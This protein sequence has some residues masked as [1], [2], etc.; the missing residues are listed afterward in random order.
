MSC[1]DCG[2]TWTGP[3]YDNDINETC[4]NCNS[5]R[6]Q[7]TPT[8]SDM[9]I[10]NMPGST[11]DDPGG[12]PQGEGIYGGQHS[13]RNEGV[14]GTMDGGWKHMFKRDESFA[15]VKKANWDPEPQH[16]PGVLFEPQSQDEAM[17]NT[18]PGEQLGPEYTQCPNCGNHVNS[19]MGVCP[20]CFTG[21]G[22]QRMATTGRTRMYLPWNEDTQHIAADFDVEQVVE[23]GP[24]TEE[25]DVGE[26]NPLIMQHDDPQT[27][28]D[29]KATLER[30]A[31]LM[32]A[33]MGG[34]GGAAGAGL[35]VALAPETGG[36]SLALP[37]AGRML[38]SAL[39]RS[40]SGGGRGGP[41]QAPAVGAPMDSTM[42]SSVYQELRGYSA[43]D[44]PSTDANMTERADGDPD[45]VDPHE[46]NDGEDKGM[47][48]DAAKGGGSGVFVPEVMDALQAAEPSL[49]H[50]MHS[51]E[52]GADDPAIKALVDLLQAHHP[53]ILEHMHEDDPEAE[54][55]LDAHT[56]N[57]AMPGQPIPPTPGV[58]PQVGTPQ[59]APM[60]GIPGAT[61]VNPGT[62]SVCPQCGA[63]TAGGPC[64]QCGALQ[65]PDPSLAPQGLAPQPIGG[66]VPPMGTFGS[67]EGAN[68]GPHSM[69]QIQAVVQYLQEHGRDDEVAQVVLHP[70]L[71]ADELAEVANRMQPPIPDPDPAAPQQ[72]PPMDPSMMQGAMGP[73]G[74]PPGGMPMTAAADP[75]APK[76]PKCDS[77]TTGVISEDGKCECS[78]CGNHW[79]SGGEVTPI[80][81]QAADDVHPHADVLNQPAADQQ[82]VNDPT[83]ATDAGVWTTSDGEPLEVGQN[84]EMYSDKYDVP[85]IIR[86]EDKRP[87]SLIYSITGEYNLNHQTHITRQEAL[88]D[89]ITFQPIGDNADM[90]PQDG[91]LNEQQPPDQMQAPQPYDTDPRVMSK[92]H[93][94]MTAKDYR[95]IADILARAP[96]QE[97]ET[98]A[99]HFADELMNTN[100]RFDRERFIQAALGQAGGRDTRNPDRDYPPDNAPGDMTLPETWAKV[101]GKKFTPNEQREFISEPGVA[102]NADKLDLKG[103][104]Y[105]EQPDLSTVD[106]GDYFLFL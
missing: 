95:L 75:I 106:L 63:R 33:I 84:Y 11:G 89:G 57:Y 92:V 21:L 37:F 74:M 44:H 28:Q 46:F 71:Y 99:N 53:E 62:Q 6:T 17:M 14:P 81:H 2:H 24:H 83:K 69:E 38:G 58:G 9:E 12:N 27:L 47:Y 82:E 43:F 31:G 39:G 66:N 8:H 101:A 55:A 61:A 98:L 1:Q 36:L 94:A 20:H 30:Q 5:Y 100:V 56:S 49:E 29:A 51:D 85:D 41:A 34:I 54:A 78:N 72:G 70:E 86:I 80:V 32:S 65:A 23:P 45:D 97:R 105:V 3:G 103:T 7:P 59:A 68:Q 40:L 79:D 15:S 67:R 52:S 10:R 104:H 42:L 4:P 87:D 102:R 88:M 18:R 91:Q 50:Y 35:G 19:R 25:V 96:V 93:E 64:P 73:G 90:Q 26:A 13:P 48:D 60:E 76:C 16:T 77:H 22:E